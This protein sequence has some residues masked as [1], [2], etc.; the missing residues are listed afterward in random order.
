MHSIEE[1]RE[2]LKDRRLSIVSEKTGISRSTLYN[3]LY[4][5]GNISFKFYEILVN[6]LFGD[7]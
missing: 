5:K 3:V 4:G 7:N 6:Y 1:I 2:K